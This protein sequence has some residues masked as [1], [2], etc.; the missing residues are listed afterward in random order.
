[1]GVQPPGVDEVM[2]E[3]LEKQKTLNTKRMQVMEKLKDLKPPASNKPAVYK[4]NTL[5]TKAHSEVD[6]HSLQFVK[7]LHDKYEETCQLCLAEVEKYKVELLT[8]QACNDDETMEI[9]N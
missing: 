2:Q 6:Q 9:V 8:T 5:L 1:M 7:T 3:M 4:W